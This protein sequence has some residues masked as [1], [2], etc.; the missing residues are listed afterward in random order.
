MKPTRRSSSSTTKADLVELVYRTH[1]GLT[2]HE[3]TEVV[4]SILRHL[5]SNLLAGKSVKIHNFGVFEVVPRR[6][7]VGVDP[8]SGKRIS[9]PA[10]RG[11]SFRPADRLKRELAPPEGER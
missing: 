11:L 8:A 6:G 1:G 2:K 9:I 10:R 5:K 7:R 3:A 4:D